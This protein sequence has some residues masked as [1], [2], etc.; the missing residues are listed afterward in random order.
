GFRYA[1]YDKV[2]TGSADGVPVAPLMGGFNDYD[3]GVTSVHL[4]PAS[5]LIAYPD[6]G[7]LYRFIARTVS[8][9]ALE[10]L[11][12]V[13]GGPRPCIDYDVEKL[14]WL[15]RVTSEADKRIIEQNQLGVASRYYEPGPYA[16]M[17]GNTRRWV[18]WYLREIA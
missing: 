17:E 1:L 11:W 18:D 9:S 5:F 6:H 14:T 13:R 12:L 15:W 3:G 2:K 10:V 4:G 16:P 8:S 7:V